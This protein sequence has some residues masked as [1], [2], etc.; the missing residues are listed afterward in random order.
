MDF[1]PLA[2]MQTLILVLLFII[3]Q[4]TKK[5]YYGFNSTINEYIF[6][7]TYFLSTAFLLN[8]LIFKMFFY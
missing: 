8:A 3:A 5:L 1:F 6:L 2:R 4:K 7:H